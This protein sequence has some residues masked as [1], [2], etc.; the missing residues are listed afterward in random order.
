[1]NKYIVLFGLFLFGVYAHSVQLPDWLTKSEE[2]SMSVEEAEK[3]IASQQGMSEIP[4]TTWKKMLEPD[5]YKILWQKGTERAFTGELLNEQRHG[6]YV[7]AGCELPV[8]SSDHKFKSGTGWPSFWEV[9]EKDNIVL[10]EDN[11]W[12][13]RRIEVLSRCGEHLGHVFDDGPD[14]TGLRY[15]IN[16]KALKFVPK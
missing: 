11:S 8:F 13:M 1:M 3:R 16:S 10:K 4:K 5:R 2:L 12:G 6:T 15:C 7:T 14:P 9:V